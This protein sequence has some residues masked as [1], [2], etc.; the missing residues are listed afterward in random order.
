MAEKERGE[1]SPSLT[2][3]QYHVLLKFC[4]ETYECTADI[5]KAFLRVGLQEEDHN[6]TKLLWI[7]D[8]SDP[9]S[10]LITYRFS[11]VFFGATSSPFLLQA[12]LDM[13]LK[14][15]NSPNKIEISNNLYVGNFQGSTSS[16]EKLLNIYNK[17]N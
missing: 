8:P 7:K 16:E 14:T 12:S 4:I 17:A 13:H 1:Q 11:S 5:S 3:R 10:E 15:F 9:N 2:Q 6:Y